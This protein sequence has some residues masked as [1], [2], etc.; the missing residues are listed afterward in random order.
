MAVA[1]P[2]GII[3]VAS[4]K[5]QGPAGMQNIM[6]GIWPSGL[7]RRVTR[8]EHEAWGSPVVDKT[9]T[10]GVDDLEWDFLYSYD[11]ALRIPKAEW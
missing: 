8:A 2:Q 10:A 5:G 4:G 1:K 3:L 7:I 9:L 11:R 6:F